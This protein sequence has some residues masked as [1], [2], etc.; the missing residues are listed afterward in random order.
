MLKMKREEPHWIDAHCHLADLRFPALGDVIERSRKARISGW[1]QGGVDPADWQ[2]QREIKKEFGATVLTA[3][4]LH[5]WWV[6]KATSG[7]IEDGIK[8][9][10]KELPEA[11]AAGEMGLDLSPKYE[12]TA[13]KQVE[14]FQRQ[15][16]LAEKLFKPMVWHIV[17]GHT[18]VLELLQKKRVQRGIIH[19]FSG[20]PEE[21][22]RYIDKGFLISISGVIARPG[23]EKVKK[24]VSTLP[25]DRLVLETDSPDQ[26]L[27]DINE[28]AFLLEVAKAAATIRRTDPETLLNQSRANLRM[29]FKSL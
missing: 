2:R 9:L 23:Y 14:V 10:E 19:S 21:A 22:R 6:A 29:L 28:P 5:P 20:S 12:L 11:D 18:Q 3:F 26:G 7:D 13:E 24:T 4:G 27:A 16:T 17:R 25:P 8:R 15:W 1:I